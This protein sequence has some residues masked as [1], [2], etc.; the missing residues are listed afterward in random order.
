M[1]LLMDLTEHGLSKE[2][3]MS[4]EE[5]DRL[6]VIEGVVGKRLK[7][8]Q[9][10]DQMGVGISKVKR[11]IKQFFGGESFRIEFT[12]SCSVSK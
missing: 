10:V 3:V 4:M 7:K 5:V 8:R 2:E 11:L 9:A 6:K 1:L 12:A